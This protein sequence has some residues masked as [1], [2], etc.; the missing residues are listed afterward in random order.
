MTDR[1]KILD[2]PIDNVNFEDAYNR[3]EAFIKGN[4]CKTIYT[5]N[6]EM[7]Y[8]ASNDANFKKVLEDGDLILP[9]GAGV[10]LASKLIRRPLKTKV[11]GVDIVNGII[12]K[13]NLKFFLL[14]GKPGIVDKAKLN[15]QTLNPK[16]KVVGVHHGYF[17]SDDDEKIIKMINTSNPDILIVGMGMKKQEEWISKYK[18]RLSTKIAIGAGGTL[19]ILS[20]ESYLTPEIIRKSGF[21]WLHRL[22][23]EPSRYKR[24]AALPLFIL[25]VL[26]RNVNKKRE[27]I[28]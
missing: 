25:K 2:I 16:S 12:K 26:F 11:S 17:S 5:P 19:D 1:I 9:D 14:G 22:I 28:K 27:H 6:S 24:M 4:S 20:G 3:I 13:Y 15:I 21:E 23:K 8:L 7:L 18:N 10:V